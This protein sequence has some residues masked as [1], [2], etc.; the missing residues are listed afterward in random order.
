MPS[1]A[2]RPPS[3]L[4]LLQGNRFIAEVIF[5]HRR[6]CTL[7]VT[8]VVENIGPATP[9]TNWVL[10]FF[11]KVVFRMWGRPAP[12]PEYQMGWHDKAA[13]GRA[14]ERVL[15]WDFVRVV[16]AHGD[17]IEADAVPALRRAWQG[18]VAPA[19]ASASPSESPESSTAAPAEPSTAAST[20]V[21]TDTIG[22]TSETATSAPQ[23][24]K[25]ECLVPIP[26]PFPSC[27]S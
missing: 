7:I 17:L 24:Q 10:R 21:P 16:L 14:L 19:A 9:N 1:F 12:A 25:A 20:T 3:P 26:P 8:D 27:L 11:W 5:L 15:A 4:A 22:C 2:A 18:L 23:A 13:A 6:S